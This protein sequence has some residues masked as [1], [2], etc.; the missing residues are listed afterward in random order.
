MYVIILT[1]ILLFLFHFF[2]NP[3]RFQSTFSSL[4]L[5]FSQVFMG[6]CRYSVTENGNASPFLP[7]SYRPWCLL[8]SPVVQSLLAVFYCVL[9]PSTLMHK[10]VQIYM[11]SLLF[12]F[13]SDIN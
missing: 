13:I 6:H 8:S 11:I 7:F 1:V 5:I 4:F 10:E 2:L 12:Y 9:L 3:V